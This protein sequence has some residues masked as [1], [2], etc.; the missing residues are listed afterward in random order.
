MMQA[1]LEDQQRA[2]QREE[3]RDHGA[4]GALAGI[5]GL[6]EGEAGLGGDQVAGGIERAHDEPRHGADEHARG[7]LAGDER[8]ELHRGR[9]DGSDNTGRSPR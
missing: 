5:E 4:L 7:R 1:G 6:R 3:G 2:D 8:G 9:R